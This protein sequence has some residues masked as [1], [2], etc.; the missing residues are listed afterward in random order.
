M[1]NKTEKKDL[2]NSLIEYISNRKYLFV[3]LLVALL[4]CALEVFVNK[5]FNFFNTLLMFVGISLVVVNL[6]NYIK[7]GVKNN[8]TSILKIAFS[9]IITIY[10]AVNYNT[11]DVFTYNMFDMGMILLIS[12]IILNFNKKLGVVIND[13]LVLLFNSNLCVY[14]FAGDYVNKIMLSNLTSIDEL[15]GNA[16][17]YISGVLLVIIFSMLRVKPIVAKIKSQIIFF[18]SI[19]I[20]FLVSIILTHNVLYYCSKSAFGGY[21]SLI[22]EYVVY[23]NK[24]SDIKSNK[25][26]DGEFYHEGVTDFI[27]KDK[28][29]A[30]KPNVIVIYTEG[31]S[32]NVIYDKREIMPN[33]KKI[34]EES[35]SFTNYYNHE[36]ATFRGLM[37]QTYSGFQFDNFDKNSLISMA[38]IMHN[39]GYYTEF[40]NTEPNNDG[41]IDFLKLLNYDKV[42]SEKK[43][44]AGTQNSIPD[45][46]AYSILI[47]EAKKLNKEEKPFLLS[48]YTVGTHMSFDSIYNKFGNG[49]SNVLNRFYD[50]DSGFG[51]FIEAFKSSE[52][53]DNT[54]LVFTADHASYVDNDYTKAFPKYKRDAQFFDQVPFFIYYKNCEPKEIDVNGRTSLN[55]APTLLDFLDITGENYFLG[56]SLF[57][58]EPTEFD[59]IYWDGSNFKKSNNSRITAFNNASSNETVQKIYNYFGIAHKEK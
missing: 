5:S 14:L 12:N 39:N 3:V 44:Y 19:I 2:K 42:V 40:Y 27:K 16:V 49:K 7:N 54:V 29:L 55:F 37:G 50:C 21:A 46:D 4:F 6:Y 43:K 56:S 9:L 26:S 17:I 22:K 32:N 18:I 11:F 20:V 47:N 53:F 45:K 48:M 13:I 58:N 59:Y 24:V 34:A 57:G 52:L 1:E 41:I 33:V 51:E 28:N 25:T 23:W 10:A 35:I 15:M 38:D 30:K 36:A 8:L 31:L